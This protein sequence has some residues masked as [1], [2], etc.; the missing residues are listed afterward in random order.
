MPIEVS[1]LTKSFGE[2]IAVNDISFIASEGEIIGF[3]G[4]NG[5]GKT[6]TFKM[7]TKQNTAS[8]RWVE[9]KNLISKKLI[10]HHQRI[11]NFKQ[12]SVGISLSVQKIRWSPTI[13]KT[14]TPELENS[15]QPADLRCV[16]AVQKSNAVKF[17]RRNKDFERPPLKEKFSASSVASSVCNLVPT[18]Q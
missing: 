6:T 17:I 11:K 8:K 4:P 14:K 15:S 12:N 7:L 5:A 13:N 9:L 1:N 10:T 16:Y 2:Q 18:L 3:L